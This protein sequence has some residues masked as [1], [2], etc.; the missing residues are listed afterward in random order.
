MSKNTISANATALPAVAEMLFAVNRDYIA[1]VEQDEGH[2]AL[3]KLNDA[4]V[5]GTLRAAK[6]PAVSVGQI[7]LKAKILSDVWS[8]S[9]SLAI[10][11]LR[12][13]LVED[14]LAL[15]VERSDVHRL[16]LTQIRY[17]LDAITA[18]VRGSDF[19]DLGQ[20]RGIIH[21][22]GEQYIQLGEVIK[23]MGGERIPRDWEDDSEDTSYGE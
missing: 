4:L 5:E 1:A 19:N 12:N 7:K 20:Q 3:E 18:A 16:C 9:T 10:E 13:S 11:S 2:P 8:G 21:L 22:L 15:G 23:E 6:T 17:A 14:V